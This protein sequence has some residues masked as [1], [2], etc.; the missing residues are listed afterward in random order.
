[1]IKA[2]LFD[3]D[4]VISVGIPDGT[5]AGQLAAQLAIPAQTA[6]EWVRQIWAPML[7]G[8]LSK[9][10]VWDIFEQ[11]YGRTIGPDQRGVWFTWD[12]L[13]PVPVMLECIKDLKTQGYPLGIVTNASGEVA[14]LIRSHH[15]YDGFDFTVISSQ[16]GMKKPDAGIFELALAK[17]PGLAP[18]EVLYLDDREHNTDAA[19]ELGMQTLYV[20]DQSHLPGLIKNTLDANSNQS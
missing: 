16:V 15:G 6:Q 19:A 3:Y 8:E 14:E 12:Q 13:K 2:L 7:K 20:T 17:L 4:G 1:M 9:A 18:S 10:E 5:I 11:K